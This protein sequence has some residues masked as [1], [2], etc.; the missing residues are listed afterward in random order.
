MVIGSV[1]NLRTIQILFIAGAA[2]LETFVLMIITFHL[3][4][5]FLR[6]FLAYHSHVYTTIAMITTSPSKFDASFKIK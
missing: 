3:L 5:F 6:A 2:F 1:Q 4:S